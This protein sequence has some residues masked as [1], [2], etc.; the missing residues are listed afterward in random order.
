MVVEEEAEV[1]V[2]EGGIVFTSISAAMGRVSLQLYYR[3][4]SS[5]ELLWAISVCRRVGT[6]ETCAFLASA[7]DVCSAC[8]LSFTCHENVLAGPGRLGTAPCPAGLG[9]AQR[10]IV[11]SVVL[12]SN[13]LINVSII[14]NR[15]HPEKYTISR[16]RMVSWACLKRP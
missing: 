4:C 8:W 6:W 10:D 11:L 14:A 3:C 16:A 9:C 12:D 13:A 15:V 2:M 5:C 1:V 7:H